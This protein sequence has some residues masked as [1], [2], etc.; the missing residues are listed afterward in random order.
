[1]PSIPKADLITICKGAA[2]EMFGRELARVN[3]NIKDVNTSATKK[4][5]IKLTFEFVPHV[6]RSGTAVNLT[7]ETQLAAVMGVQGTTYITRVP[8]G[9]EAYTQD[10]AQADLFDE[11][12][13]EV[14]TQTERK[15]IQ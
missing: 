4:R 2:L 11:D 15:G 12:T 6:D 10:G 1:M 9:F 13:A 7:A 8:G 3:A 5:K 14:H